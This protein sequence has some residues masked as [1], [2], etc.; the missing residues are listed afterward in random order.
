MRAAVP[1][2]LALLGMGAAAVLGWTG[3]AL[4]T[5]PPPQP[6]L[7]GYGCEGA[8]G[9]LYAN[10]ED[11]F[12]PC[13]AIE[14]ADAPPPTWSLVAQNKQG[15]AFTFETGA[16]FRDCMGAAEA[17]HAPAFDVIYCE[18]EGAR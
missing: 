1:V 15:S 7:A 5:Q 16:S 18:R 14:K 6:R 2:S 11:E 8:P 13:A 3:G 12:P 10:G 4:S 9:V 17:L